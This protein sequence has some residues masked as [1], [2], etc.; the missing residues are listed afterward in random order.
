[1]QTFTDSKELAR[2][3]DGNNLFG[4]NNTFNLSDEADTGSAEVQPPRINPNGG[5]DK[6]VEKNTTAFNQKSFLSHMA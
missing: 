1:M 3:K 2:A 6:A 5:N 4:Q